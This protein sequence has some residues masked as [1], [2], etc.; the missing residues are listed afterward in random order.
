MSNKFK[1]FFNS[2]FIRFFAAETNQQKII[3][4]F[5]VFLF[6]A[7]SLYL[8]YANEREMNYDFNKNWWLAYFNEPRDQSV[9]FILENHSDSSVFDYE[10]MI[11]KNK[12][13]EE[14][15]FLEKGS[16]LKIDLDKKI[17]NA[18]NEKI[19]IR[20]SDKKTI[21]EIYKNF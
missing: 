19:T 5:I 7:S 11:G 15:I 20:I 14:K 10:I 6:I 4:A 16:F 18:E 9:N 1:N 17:K 3:I 21:Q 2:R 12:I 13:Y 8:F